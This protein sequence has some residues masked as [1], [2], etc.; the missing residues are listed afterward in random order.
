[1]IRELL[2]K[3]FLVTTAFMICVLFGYKAQTWRWLAS[4]GIN[5]SEYY[6]STLK[7]SKSGRLLTLNSIESNSSDTR[8][9]LRSLDQNGVELWHIEIHSLAIKDI[10]FD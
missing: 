9:V 3:R 2:I 7:V 5:S 8:S 1:M 4:T 10:C 6:T